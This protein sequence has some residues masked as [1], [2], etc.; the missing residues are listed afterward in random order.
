MAM[1]VS[2]LQ[3]I[4][5]RKR[6]VAA[7]WR[8]R[9]TLEA[10]LLYFLKMLRREWMATTRISKSVPGLSGTLPK[11]T[12]EMPLLPSLIMAH[13]NDGNREVE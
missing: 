7:A 9:T 11:M 10:L 3:N 12:T 4:E 13:A 6:G 1:E 5:V 2:L 8:R